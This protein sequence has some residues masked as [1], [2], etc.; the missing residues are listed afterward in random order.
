VKL[1]TD[2]IPCNINA[3]LKAIRELTTEEN[4][5]RELLVEIMKI[6]ALRGLDWSIT[7]SQLVE[8]VFRKITAAYDDPDPFRRRKDSQNEK[9]LELYPWLKSLV[10]ESEDPL[11][12][13][14][15]LAIAGNSIDPMGYLSS[16]EVEQAIRGSLEHPVCRNPFSDL[17]DRL[18]KSSLV[19][20]L[21]DNCGE[22]VFDRLLIE[23][24]KAHYD[25]EVAFVVRSIP[26]LNDATLREAELV[27]MDHTATVMEN[28]ID[29]PLPG[30]ILSRCSEQLQAL[31]SRADL[32]ISK[33]GGNFDSL[34]EEENI[35]TPIYY[36]LICKCI[37]YEYHFGIPLSH[38]V[39]ALA[40][41]T[42]QSGCKTS[43][44]SAHTIPRSKQVVHKLGA[45]QGRIDD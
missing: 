1:R 17:K 2:C 14:V 20:Y 28:G 43:S 34:D 4:A 40:S 19:I 15:N 36:M 8:Q 16:E 11:F 24:I 3:A 42:S 12:T 25:I 39:L 30:T 33:G 45:G 21:G 44:G 27:G 35:T 22:I 37:P 31:W 32:V 7:G 13:A 38:P 26:A 23:T 18:E 29:G 41:S 9:C 5:T 10:A 6:P